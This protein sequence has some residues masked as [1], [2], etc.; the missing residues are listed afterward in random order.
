[1]KVQVID[2]TTGE[3]VDLNNQAL[4][5]EATEHTPADTDL[6][7]GVKAVVFDADGTMTFKNSGA[8][9]TGYPVIKGQ[10]LAFIPTQITAMTGPAKCFLIT[11][12]R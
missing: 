9:I 8:A 12:N 11:G 6:P 4:G 10:P 2:P 3:G 1:M 7:A 5:K